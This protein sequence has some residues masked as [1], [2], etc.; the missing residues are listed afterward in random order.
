MLDRT[1]LSPNHREDVSVVGASNSG[2]GPEVYRHEPCT[3]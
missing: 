1:P 3:L 2:L